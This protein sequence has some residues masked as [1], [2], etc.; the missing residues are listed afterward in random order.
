MTTTK[1][2]ATE[3]PTIE[4]VVGSLTGFDELA[5]E[6]AFGESFGDLG[7]SM[8]LRALV[9][10]LERRTKITDKEAYGIAMRKT[11]AEVRDTFAPDEDD[12]DDE[13]AE[14]EV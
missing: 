12:K 3:K 9:F 10:V 6:K 7:G 11:L 4:Y 8:S 2:T 1:D 13:D 5:I 14:G